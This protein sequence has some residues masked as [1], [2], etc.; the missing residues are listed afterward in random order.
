MNKVISCCDKCK[1]MVKAMKGV[2]LPQCSKVNC[3][4]HIQLAKDQL[5]Q[6]KQG[7]ESRYDPKTPEEI[8]RNI[9]FQLG[10][11]YTLSTK[12]RQDTNDEAIEFV[13]RLVTLAVQ[14]AREED[15]PKHQAILRVTVSTAVRAE[16]KRIISL[17][18]G[19]VI[20]MIEPSR[21]GDGKP[22]QVPTD[23]YGKGWNEAISIMQE[24]LLK[25]DTKN[26]K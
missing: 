19:K 5:P 21:F 2:Y 8:A 22:T 1:K 13:T 3:E 7:W 14:A 17:I 25:E 4:C 15:A 11:F 24:R 6:D 18:P 20:T 10:D 26:D 9:V 23:Q 16:R 12:L